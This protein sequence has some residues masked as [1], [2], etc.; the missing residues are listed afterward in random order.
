MLHHLMTHVNMHIR[1]N[2][3]FTFISAKMVTS[4]FIFI[5]SIF[6]D[7][8]ERRNTKATHWS[9]QPLINYKIVLKLSEPIQLLMNSDI[10]EYEYF[11]PNCQRGL[12]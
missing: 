5:Q 6:V 2:Y 8:G 1:L 10:I 11:H 3:Y 4:E 7:R 9:I 12:L